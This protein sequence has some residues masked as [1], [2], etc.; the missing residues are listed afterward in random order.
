MLCFLVWG[1]FFLFFCIL[2]LSID[3]LLKCFFSLHLFPIHSF[4]SFLLLSL[5][6]CI[7][8]TVHGLNWTGITKGKRYSQ[9]HGFLKHLSY[10]SRW[11][12]GSNIIYYTQENWGAGKGNNLH[13]SQRGFWAMLELEPGTVSLVFNRKAEISAAANENRVK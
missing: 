2:A 8:F 11:I 4:P 6:P 13:K 3:F 9:N 12:S 1:F 7:F 10:T 5:S